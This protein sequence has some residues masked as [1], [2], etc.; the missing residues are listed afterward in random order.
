MW[1]TKK[2]NRKNKNFL[3]QQNANGFIMISIIAAMTWVIASES[4]NESDK[5]DENK[6]QRAKKIWAQSGIEP[7]TSRTRSENH[8]IRPLSLINGS[9]TGEADPRA[10]GS[11]GPW[12]TLMLVPRIY[13]PT[14]LKTAK[15]R[16]NFLYAFIRRSH[17]H[18]SLLSC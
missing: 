11:V 4:M 7:E 13:I 6:R 10:F 15:S 9:R 17:P 2:I 16:A 8:T 14:G 1:R 5:N 12:I 18:N 3:F